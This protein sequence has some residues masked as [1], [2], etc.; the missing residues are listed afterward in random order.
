M[1]S[2]IFKSWFDRLIDKLTGGSMTDNVVSAQANA[3]SAT[4]AQKAVFGA[5]VELDAMGNVIEK[6]IGSAWANLKKAV[7]DVEHFVTKSAPVPVA[8]P[9]PMVPPVQSVVSPVV[10]VQSTENPTSPA[11]PVTPAVS[12]ASVAPAAPVAATPAADHK[13][14]LMAK[15]KALEAELAAS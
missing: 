14:D 11:A 9:A 1:T 3:V 7:A 12:T 5:D 8:V 4:A 10:T 13:A 6:G 2:K 15:L